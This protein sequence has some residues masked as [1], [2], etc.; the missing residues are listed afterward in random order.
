MTPST[1]PS[2]PISGLAEPIV[3]S[4]GTKRPS[5]SRTAPLS[6]SSTSRSASTCEALSRALPIVR[7]SERGRRF[8]DES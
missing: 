3:A 6:E 2:R 4:Q 8:V 7:R 5:S 1:V